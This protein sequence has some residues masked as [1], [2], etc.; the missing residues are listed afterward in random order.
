MKKRILLEKSG[1]IYHYR[2]EDSKTMTYFCSPDDWA[3]YKVEEELISAGAD[4]KLVE[5]LRHLS[6]SSGYDEA[7][8]EY[9]AESY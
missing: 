1:G 3:I 7:G 2:F 9:R 4:E 5:E 6:Y 8:R